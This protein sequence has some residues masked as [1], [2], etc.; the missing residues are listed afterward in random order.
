MTAVVSLDGAVVLMVPLLMALAR[1]HR[2]PL[3][4]LFLGVITVA[5]AASVAVPQGNPTNLVLMGQL[6]LLPSAFLAH[7]FVPGLAA[8]ALCAGTGGA[9]RTADPR[10]RLRGANP[11]LDTALRPGTA[12]LHACCCRAGRVAGT[13]PRTRAL[14]A[15]DHR[16]R[17]LAPLPA[18][19]AAALDPV[20]NRRTDRRAP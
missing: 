15:V 10:D 19:T 12:G 2:A 11:Q 13:A 7:M 4:A 9:A 5:N 16:R 6:G 1:E 17:R 14:V 3:T 8:A 18:R 20:A